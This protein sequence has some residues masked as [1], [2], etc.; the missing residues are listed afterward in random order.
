VISTN[1]SYTGWLIS[2]NVPRKYKTNLCEINFSLIARAVCVFPIPEEPHRKINGFGN[3]EDSTLQIIFSI[4]RISLEFSIIF[5]T[6]LYAFRYS[7][8]SFTANENATS[9]GRHSLLRFLK[10]FFSSEETLALQIFV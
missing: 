4:S 8:S 9:F 6:S 1:G 10:T 3:A 7:S 2:D 5:D